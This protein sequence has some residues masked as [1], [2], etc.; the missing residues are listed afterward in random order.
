MDACCVCGSLWFVWA[1]TL[2]SQVARWRVCVYGGFPSATN[3][4]PEWPP[5][6]ARLNSLKDVW[7]NLGLIST[8]ALHLTADFYLFI[9]PTPQSDPFSHWLL[10]TCSS[11]ALLQLACGWLWSQKTSVWWTAA[12]K[13]A[14]FS[15]R[16]QRDS[17][18]QPLWTIESQA[19]VNCASLSVSLCI[20]HTSG[21][22]A[23]QRCHKYALVFFPV[24]AFSPLCVGVG[25]FV[26]VQKKNLGVNK[27]W[28][29]DGKWSKKNPLE[30]DVDLDKRTQPLSMIQI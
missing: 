16:N 2:T 13:L 23:L 9:I 10:I 1:E 29:E 26:C 19:E 6:S 17:T 8:H 22:L 20:W 24:A 11:V 3:V 15:H 18:Q 21:E 4:N 28:W 27:T 30:W 14:A 7:L 12:L 5:W 25:S